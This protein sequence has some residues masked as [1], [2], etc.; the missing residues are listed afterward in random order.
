MHGADPPS[1][2]NSAGYERSAAVRL[3]EEL[4]AGAAI[5]AGLDPAD[6]ARGKDGRG[7]IG[8]HIRHNLDFVECFLRGAQA[9]LIDYSAR[10]RQA[11]VE[12]DPAAA[13]EKIGRLA[14]ALRDMSFTEG[15]LI[16]VRSETDP[17]T[18]YQSSIGRELEFLHS[19][20]I[21]HYALISERLKAIGAE[22]D[23]TF[24]VAP[25]TLRFW[26]GE[27]AGGGR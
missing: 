24:G 8:A 17:S 18:V 15:E 12:T 3:A 1:F 5:V 9:G 19:H 21:H 6:Y 23:E 2:Q 22:T 27:A 11:S 10:E 25:S 13:I 7:S 4:T 20:T 14:A 26:K 16:G